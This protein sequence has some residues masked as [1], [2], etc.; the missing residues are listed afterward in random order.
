MNLPLLR[1][2]FAN[3]SITSYRKVKV[4]DFPVFLERMGDLLKEGYTFPHS[5]QM[6]LP[7]HIKQYEDLQRKVSEVLQDGGGA[8]QVLNLLGLEKQYLVSI[9][10]SEMTGQ[11]AETVQIVSQQLTFQQEMKLKLVKVLSYPV[12]LFVFLMGLFLAFRTYF[13]PNI[14]TMVTSRAQNEVSTSVQWSSFL[15]HMPDYIIGLVVITFSIVMTFIYYIKRKRVDLQLTLLFKIPLLGHFWKLLL[16]RHFSRVLGNLLL[17][18]FSLQQALGHLK[19]QEHQIQIAYVAQLLQEKVIL[20]DSLADAVQI[21]GF[22]YPKFEHFIAH[23]EASG[24]LGRELILY[25]ELLDKRLQVTIRFLMTIIQPLLFMIIA[26]CVIAA[27]L[28]ILI[29]MYDVLDFI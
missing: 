7:F 16:T 1:R 18:G 24:M 3:L 6:L 21:D 8:T 5:I 17:A 23:G 26:A 28:S 10:L 29:P 25:C 27:Y 9:E 22:F 4:L 2:R 14:S 11:L 15:L 19:N 12:L 20:G 13:L